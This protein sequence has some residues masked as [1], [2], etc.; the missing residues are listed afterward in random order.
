MIQSACMGVLS[1]LTFEVSVHATAT[2]TA[3]SNAI[4]CVVSM[5]VYELITLYGTIVHVA[6]ILL[7]VND[8]CNNIKPP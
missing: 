3:I 4:P 8:Q 5:K 7:P 1:R 2:V 6:L